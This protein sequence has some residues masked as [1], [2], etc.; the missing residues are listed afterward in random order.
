MNAPKIITIA[1]THLVFEYTIS[2]WS[3]TARD[4]RT[5][6]EVEQNKNAAS[7]TA[8]V[9]VHLLGKCKELLA[10][11]NIEQNIRKTVSDSLPP[12]GRGASLVRSISM[13]DFKSKTIDPF[14]AKFN[15]AADDFVKVYPSLVEKAY[16]RL[17]DLL[18][19]SK[20]PKPSRIREKFSFTYAFFPVPMNDFRVAPTVEAA[21]DLNKFY[22]EEMDRRLKD[23]SLDAWEKLRKGLEWASD[24]LT[25]TGE[26][27]AR[28]MHESSM[29]RFMG[30]TDL[31]REF[32]LTGDPKLE[33]ERC[34]L[35]ALFAGR[36]PAGMTEELK[37]SPD[38]RVELKAKV[39]SML[40]AL[41]FD[42]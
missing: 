13:L 19:L 37:E 23:A 12:F 16:E 40:S 10:I 1:D 7:G 39:D 36:T 2:C 34:R 18:D 26:G 31:L 42:L 28:R 9:N 38:A 29:G 41:D 25:D 15:K 33:A 4:K 27:K 5:S 32:N 8:S 22:A 11:R 3:A 14:E 30:L 17:G 21:A 20:F 6:T 24:I 35:E